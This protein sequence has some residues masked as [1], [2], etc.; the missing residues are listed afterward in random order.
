MNRLGFNESDLS[1]AA[2]RLRQIAIVKEIRLMTHFATADE[3][4]HPLTGHQLQRFATASASITASRS[5]G[6]RSATVRR[7]SQRD[8]RASRSSRPV[9][10]TDFRAAVRRARRSW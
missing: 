7:G 9:T 4:E 8:R 10:R 2:M 3:S 6:N 5:S 1:V